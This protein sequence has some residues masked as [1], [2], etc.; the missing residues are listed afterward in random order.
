MISESTYKLSLLVF[1]C[2]FII[3]RSYYSKKYL[4]EEEELFD[5]YPMIVKI[6]AFLSSI[7]ILGFSVM[8]IF[9][10]LLEAFSMN[11]PDGIRLIGL[12]GYL[13]TDLG[14][15][16]VLH[17]L[18][19]NFSE[20]GNERSIIVTGPYRYVR[21]PMYIVFILWGIST[22]LSASNWLSV[23]GVP[24]MLLLVVLR[25]PIEEKKLLSKFGHNYSNYMNTTGRLIPNFR[26]KQ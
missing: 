19:S 2:I 18:G 3:I 5:P 24:L 16:W 23:F 8:Y 7:S 12:F 25:T 26:K 1:L 13:V 21:H 20:T 14:M 9:T 6:I 15:W 11:L 4:A 17:E 22:A 10:N